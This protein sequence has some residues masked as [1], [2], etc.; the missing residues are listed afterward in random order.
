VTE[1]QPHHSAFG[2]LNGLQVL[3][4]DFNFR[5]GLAAFFL[6]AHIFFRF[7]LVSGD[8]IKRNALTYL[9]PKK[10]LVPPRTPLGAA[11]SSRRMTAGS[12]G[13]FGALDFVVP[14]FRL[15]VSFTPCYE[16]CGV[17]NS[18]EKNR[19]Q[20]SKKGKLPKPFEIGGL[21]KR[22]ARTLAK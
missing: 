4:L 7:G 3:D 6:G 20:A 5:S 10:A 18:E 13:F 14:T 17:P 11:R 22:I 8:E 9:L 15:F 2:I 16:S 19:A 12:V 1:L 21:A